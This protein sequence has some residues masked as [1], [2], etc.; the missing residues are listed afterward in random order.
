MLAELIKIPSIYLY[1][2][3]SVE[4]IEVDINNVTRKEFVR[5]IKI[6]EGNQECQVLIY[7]FFK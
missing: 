4:V 5:F 1:E 7:L 2:E 6:W 3:L